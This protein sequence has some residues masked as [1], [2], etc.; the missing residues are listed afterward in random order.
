MIK[1]FYKYLKV[2]FSNQYQ[3]QNILKRDGVTIGKDCEICKDVM[4]GS[5]P[6]M[7]TLGNH[8]RITSGCKFI[9]HDGGVWV[10]RKL[11]NEETID[12]FGK[13]TIKDNVHIGINAIIMPGVTIGENCIIGCG[14][15]V[16]KSIPA[17]QIWGGVPAKFIK[18]IDEYYDKNESRFDYTKCLNAKEKRKYLDKKYGNR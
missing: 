9:T 16:T 15:V 8:V 18:T 1:Q 13:I 7:I 12:M 4:F 3:Y 6:Y 2:R 17:N 10:L 11:K 5:E 14:A